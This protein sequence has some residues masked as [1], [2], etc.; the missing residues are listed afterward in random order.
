MLTWLAVQWGSFPKGLGIASV[1]RLICDN[2][3]TT[4]TK[5]IQTLYLFFSA[6]YIRNN[7]F[8]CSTMNVKKASS[9]NPQMHKPSTSSP[10]RFMVLAEL[11]NIGPEWV[12]FS[13]YVGRPEAQ[14]PP[15]KTAA[16]PKSL[17]RPSPETSQGSKS[18]SKES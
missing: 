9:V 7:S 11:L 13:Q 5:D 8:S 16:P 4:H 1:T 6:K 17:G 14:T 2:H 3:K 18:L 10:E 12:N 15:R